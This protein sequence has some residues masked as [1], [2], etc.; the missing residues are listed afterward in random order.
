VPP[1]RRLRLFNNTASSFKGTS[2]ETYEVRSV[3][4]IL[5][6]RV[7]QPQQTFRHWSSE[8]GG[9][10]NVRSPRAG[11]RALVGASHP[12]HQRVLRCPRQPVP[13]AGRS[14]PASLRLRVATRAHSFA[15]P[16]GC[17][18]GGSHPCPVES[19]AQVVSH[20]SAMTRGLNL[21]GREKTLPH[22]SGV[23]PSFRLESH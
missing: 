16:S 10:S 11:P 15:P 20:L 7:R 19:G 13:L 5:S 8:E 18:H 4:Q 23:T 21:P 1:N 22:S 12:Q 6:C 17:L 14:P 2:A 3:T 9:P